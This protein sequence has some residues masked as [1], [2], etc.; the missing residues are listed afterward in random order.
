MG[1]RGALGITAAPLVAG[2]VWGVPGGTGAIRL[3]AG[4]GGATSV[5]SGTSGTSGSRLAQVVGGEHAAGA[6]QHRVLGGVVGV[7]LGGDLQH[8]RQRA[9]VRLDDVPDQLGDALV[10]QDDA[11]VLPAQEAPEGLLDLGHAGLLLHHQEVGLAVLVELA[12][13]AQQE[14]GHRVLSEKQKEFKGEICLEEQLG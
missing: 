12:H 13:A 4:A 2:W 7:L 3:G 11:D 5:T 9:R 8:G 6:A 14:A 10:D 1:Q